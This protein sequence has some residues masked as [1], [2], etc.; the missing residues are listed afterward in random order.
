MAKRG[1]FSKKRGLGI[2]EVLVAGVIMAMSLAAIASMFSFGFRVTRRSDDKSVA[3]NISRKELERIRSEGFKNTIIVRNSEGVITSQGRDGS[4]TVYYNT[5][6]TK[7]SNSSGATYSVSI[8]VTSDRSDTVGGVS[9]PADDALRTVLISVTSLA[10][11]TVVFS[12]GTYLTRS[13]L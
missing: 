5:S 2:V 12:D 9:R 3:Y 10:D 4:E 11:N 7:L 6:G 1:R 8:T 13:G